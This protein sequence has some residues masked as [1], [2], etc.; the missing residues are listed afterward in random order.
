MGAPALASRAGAC[1]AAFRERRPTVPLS[2]RRRLRRLLA[3][4]PTCQAPSTRGSRL[5]Q[6]V[7]IPSRDLRPLFDPR[8]VAVVG[9][10]ADTSK[11]GGDVAA[12][13]VR[14]ETARPVYLVNRKGGAMHGRVAYPSLSDLPE[15]P[16][17]VILAM[18][19]AAFEATLDEGLALGSRAFVAIF[20][21]LGETGPRGAARECLAARRLREAGALM[22]GPNCMGLADHTSGLQAVA[23]LDVPRGAI[24]FISQ[25]GAMGEEFV[26]RART[27]GCGF[28]RY[29]TLG[30]QAD[31]GIAEV[32]DAF[33]GHDATRVVALYAEGLR[34]GRALAEAAARVVAAG[35]PVVLLAPGR[36]AAG[37]RAAR[38]HTGS[39]A[40]STAVLYAVCR[41]TGVLRVDT[42][43]ELFEVTA[44]LLDAPRPRGRRVAVITEG[45][46]HGG[47]AAD[48]LE[49]AGLRVPAFTDALLGRLREAL[50]ESAGTNPLD[51]A[52]GTTEPD[53]Y[54]RALPVVAGADE[55]D[56]VFA[57][58]QLG[59]WAARFPEFAEL[60]AAEV[61]G[62]EAMAASAR[63]A[64]KPLV[65]S[66]V[67][68][69]AAPGARLR[70][71]GVPV[72]REIASAVGALAALVHVAEARP[73]GVPRLPPPAASLAGAPDYWEAREALAAAGLAVV[74]GR[75]VTGAAEALAAARELGY[76]VALKALG[77]LHKSDA[78][79][80]ALGLDAAAALLA[81]LADFE[82]RLAPPACIVE[83][84]APLADGIELIV[85]CRRDPLFGPVSLVGSGG[86]YAELLR[87]TRTALAPLDAG[88]AQTLLAELRAAPLLS[89]ARGRPALDIAA[90]AAA[91]AAV[92]R[93]AAAHPEV[94]EVEVNPLLVLPSGALALDAR[95]VLRAAEDDADRPDEVDP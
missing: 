51:F 67:Y 70:A 44:G 6:R 41:A 73:S 12:R 80:V 25:S 83:R 48:A 81:A 66:T 84:M 62:A 8:S 92:S 13:L 55:V 79:A 76:P 11:W 35:R 65:V 52:L 47:I 43:R 90:A 4:G 17:L 75:R 72:Y 36:T 82:A 18:P 78:G 33:G 50:P 1:P 63:S 93:F 31:V 57:V 69:D 61:E 23:Y 53:A 68:P 32:L 16:E 38:S 10:S 3:P 58:G 87:D 45:G 19:A 42:P 77:P 5:T 40:S 21:G 89:G 95:I 64:G 60:V 71:A 14:N 91:A 56:A 29:V 22:I 54:A 86:V 20:A 2:A 24:G 27:W 59:Y 46:G 30:N 26:A 7:P 74:E 94:E 85:G 9:A 15:T 28:S 37:A 49:A 88:E 34:D 39:L